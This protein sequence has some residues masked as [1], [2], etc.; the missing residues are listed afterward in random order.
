MAEELSKNFETLQLH[1]GKLHSIFASTLL[2]THHHRS[3]TRLSDKLSSCANL[4]DYR[5][6]RRVYNVEAH[7]QSNNGSPMSSMTP[8]M[9][10]GY[11]VSRSLETYTHVL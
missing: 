7:C 3:H 9:A 6:F 4:R 8:H 11:L 2:L 5:T 10:R 1:A